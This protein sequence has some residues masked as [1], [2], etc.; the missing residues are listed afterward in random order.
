MKF[1]TPHWEQLKQAIKGKGLWDMVSAD[2]KEAV[3]KLTAP[4]TRETFDPLIAA[5]NMIINASL[6]MVGP[7]ALFGEETAEKHNCPLCVAAEAAAR[8]LPEHWIAGA[9]RDVA[10]IAEELKDPSKILTAIARG[11]QPPPAP[12]QPPP[13]KV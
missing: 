1:C 9:S 12:P 13:E 8:H 2:G 10:R 5:H 4:Q 3:Q 6:E 7:A 11:R